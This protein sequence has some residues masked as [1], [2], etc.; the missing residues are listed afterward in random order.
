MRF[1]DRFFILM[2]ALLVV[3]ISVGLASFYFG[4]VSQYE[5]ANFVAEL[6]GRAETLI[7]AAV[8]FLIAIRIIQL[9]F[10]SRN[11]D[12]QTIIGEGELG[13]VRITIEAINNFV[14]D[15]VR[16]EANTTDTQSK[17]KVTEEGLDVILNLT[18]YDKVKVPNLANQIQEQVK[19]EIEEA[20][21]AKVDQVEVLIKAIEKPKE[22]NKK[23]RLD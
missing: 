5:V 19:S 13:T 6:G 11:K 12:K 2:L 14:K 20:I 8:L 21:G 16:A 1:L 23:L 18:V 7:V 3:A 22:K 10:M 15:V 4:V 17:V 9:S